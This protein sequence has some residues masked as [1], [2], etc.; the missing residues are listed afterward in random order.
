[1]SQTRPASVTITRHPRGLVLRFLKRQA[2]HPNA[3]NYS[4]SELKN[5]FIEQRGAAEDFPERLPP[6]LLDAWRR[7]ARVQ[8]LDGQC[9]ADCYQVLCQSQQ[10]PRHSA[11]KP[12]RAWLRLLQARS[13]GRRRGSKKT[14]AVDL[15]PALCCPERRL[16]LFRDLRPW[17]SQAMSLLQ[18]RGCQP[19]PKNQALARPSKQ[20]ALF[21]RHLKPHLK[22]ASKTL[23]RACL[24]AYWALQLDQQPKLLWAFEEMLEQS[25]ERAL[26]WVPILASQLPERRV[27]C[28]HLIITCGLAKQP[29][30][31]W[32]PDLL[33]ARE[34]LCTHHEE[35][36]YRQQLEFVFTGLKRGLTAE[37]MKSGLWV[38]DRS[39]SLHRIPT[40]ACSAYQH[41][42]FAD[43]VKPC[44]EQNL[45]SWYM[46]RTLWYLLNAKPGAF[47]AFKA[48][49]WQKITEPRRRNHVLRLINTA[50]ASNYGWR[51]LAGLF[52]D[53][54]KAIDAYPENQQSQAF[55]IIRDLLRCQFQQAESEQAWPRI[56]K[57]VPHLLKCP[58]VDEEDFDDSLM[59][60]LR[61]LT[62][63][64]FG[65]LVSD[66]QRA[67]RVLS[68]L[69]DSHRGYGRENLSK[70]G[71]KLISQRL[72]EAAGLW[73]T[74]PRAFLSMARE[75]ALL[76][77]HC[78][79]T[80]LQRWRGFHRDLSDVDQFQSLQRGLDQQPLK[81]GLRPFPR[82]L[83]E[84]YRGQRRLTPGQLARAHRRTQALAPDFLL[85][86]LR[87][88]IQERQAQWLS[89]EQFEAKTVH[90]SLRL[91]ATVEDNKRALKKYLRA[92]DRG[93]DDYLERHPKNQQWL[94]KQS[95]QTEL[96]LGHWPRQY[97]T[98]GAETVLD[99][100][101]RGL[102]V[103]R[104]GS[105]VGSCLSVG[106][107][108]CDSVVSLLLDAN[109]QVVVARDAKGH[110]L[111][112]QNLAVTAEGRLACFEV[113]PNEA[114][115]ELQKH[116]R[117]YD[118][119]LAQALGL[120]LAEDE[121]DNRLEALIGHNFYDDG[122]WDTSD[123]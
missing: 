84:H 98:K 108:N 59:Q 60:L 31:Q 21:L 101:R 44:R 50:L 17:H 15:R 24:G 114:P 72:P 56:L 76:P 33:A 95:F 39:R 64:D 90:H 106:G 1:M 11:P 2:T 115:K 68:A 93:Q 22:H 26:D 81:D 94:A 4:Q 55:S 91:L 63:A 119:A 71:L 66:A 122:L 88:L 120:S 113:Y 121:H 75:L 74:R 87:A 43:I 85:G 116:F 5:L 3:R 34:Q 97:S 77:K 6:H 92:L 7:L 105:L 35:L 99:F 86:A 52:E 37:T 18:A 123:L 38:Q 23:S 82:V 12:E 100:E 80:V 46:T 36:D 61:T 112:R 14:R 73:L 42:F 9:L 48:L 70:R 29:V 19:A 79:S 104:M 51:K 83:S 103:L 45:F 32:L 27:L 102:E 30:P 110:F 40:A 118:L 89:L 109:K 65:A 67:Q 111:A 53:M 57:L 96:W 49:P 25:I 69:I 117:D 28:A 10:D 78:L 107:E 54:L 20:P 58:R 16:E 62:D 13:K 8:R 41:Q 47:S